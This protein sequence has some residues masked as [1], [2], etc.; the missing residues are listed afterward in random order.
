MLFIDFD[1]RFLKTLVELK[2]VMNK[3]SSDGTL[4]LSETLKMNHVGRSINFDV[5]SS[6]LLDK[7]HLSFWISRQTSLKMKEQNIW[8]RL[9]NRIRWK[10][11][12][13]IV[14]F[15]RFFVF[16]DTLHVESR[17]EQHRKRWSRTFESS[18]ENESSENLFSMFEC[19]FFINFIETFDI[20]S[21]W[22]LDWWCRCK[23]FT[24]R[25][26]NQ[27]GKSNRLSILFIDVIFIEFFNRLSQHSI[28]N[29][30]EFDLL[31]K[32]FSSILWKRIKWKK[33]RR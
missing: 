13:A 14:F 23:T 12:F 5:F 1:V 33:L 7:R 15:E 3:I 28:W 2:L 30:I 26:E 8:P 10:I 9:S 20:E 17:L 29:R 24:W 25:I 16:L 21:F 4:F 32:K 27:Y 18:V 22:E 31:I 11:D 19:R 6:F